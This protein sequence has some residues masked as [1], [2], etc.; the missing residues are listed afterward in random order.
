MLEKRKKAKK[1]SENLFLAGCGCNIIYQYLNNVS[2]FQ[3]SWPQYTVEV[4]IAVVLAGLVMRLCTTEEYRVKRLLLYAVCIG[5]CYIEWKMNGSPDVLYFC[6]FVIG[7]QDI[8]ADKVIR[9]YGSL[10]VTLLGITVV[11]ALSGKIENLIYHRDGQIRIAFGTG[12]PTIFASQILFL[13][14]CYIYCR[15]KNL[16]KPDYF[17]GLAAAAFVYGFCKARMS[18]GCLILFVVGLGVIRLYQNRRKK[19]KTLEKVVRSSGT[20]SIYAPVICALLVLNS[21]I[22]YQSGSSV[23]SKVDQLFSNRLSLGQEG[24]RLYGITAW[25]TNFPQYGNGGTTEAAQNYFYIDSA[26]LSYLLRYGFFVL[27]L[28]TGILMLLNFRAYEKKEYV[29]LWILMIIAV[30]GIVEDRMLAIVTNPFL[31]LVFSRTG[32]KKEE[33][34]QR[35]EEN[36]NELEER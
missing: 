14:L 35:S 7:M 31:W 4:L 29:L 9:A 2:M 1:I 11:A 36:R 6:I 15:R 13:Y 22:F 20:L 34:M 23:W 16:R 21:C 25:G 12:Y 18:A 8:C 3:I 26:Y 30:H 19:G 28:V 5:I 10:N 27:L 24:L 32:T 33:E 17:L